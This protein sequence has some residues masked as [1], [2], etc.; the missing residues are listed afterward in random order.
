MEPF[1]SLVL[2]LQLSSV[3]ITG[4]NSIILPSN[5][6]TPK[7]A[8]K[9]A[10]DVKTLRVAL[11]PSEPFVYHDERG[12]SINGI[13]FELVKTIAKKENLNVSFEIQRNP[14]QLNQTTLK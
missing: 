12:Q 8:W 11:I 6:Y 14:L 10:E 5:E 2:L 7:I 9:E 3:Q 13:E 1:A 4:V